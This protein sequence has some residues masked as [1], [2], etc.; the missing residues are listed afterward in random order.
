MKKIILVLVLIVSQLSFGQEKEFTFTKDGF[1]DF[2]VTD[3]SGK[4]QAELY[5]KC[6]D[7]ISVT[8]KNPK[9]V[10]KAQIENDYIRFE[11]S[12]DGLICTNGFGVKSCYNTKY[13]I[14]VS[15][16]EGKYKFDIIDMKFYLGAQYGWIDFPLNG[17][18]SYY[19]KNGIIKKMNKH[20][21]EMIPPYFNDLNK[22][23]N[24]FIVSNE[25]P[26]KKSDW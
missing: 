24:D 18:K 1:T 4:T 13:Q 14:E 21:P 12:K 16:K 23:L 2:V 22:S 17:V 15:F 19:D 10:L 20:Y 26:S 3:C 11:G 8:Y 9:E 5:K 25:I 7:W 6:M